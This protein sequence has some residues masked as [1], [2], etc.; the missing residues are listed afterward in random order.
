MDEPIELTAV[1]ELRADAPSPDAARLAALRWRLMA[2]VAAETDGV[3]ARPAR[4]R[5]PGHRAVRRT[6]VAAATAAAVTS[7]VLLS[8]PGPAGP[9]GPSGI[10]ARPTTA[11]T[12]LTMAAAH[13]ERLSPAV[14]GP[15]QWA[16]VTAYTCDERP[17]PTT[18]AEKTSWVRGDGRQFM[19]T[20][21]AGRKL[22]LER[23]GFPDV[24]YRALSRWPTEPHALL[25]KMGRDPRTQARQIMTVLAEAPAVP[26]RI[27]AALFRAL[28]L[29]PGADLVDRPVKDAMGRR[30]TAIDYRFSEQD[31]EYLILNPR[32]YAYL[33]FRTVSYGRTTAVAREVT[34]VVDHP[35]QLP[36][37]PVPPR[38]SHG[39]AI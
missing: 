22:V 18:C 8:L 19:V 3:P 17:A 16:Y 14:P 12:V 32:T 15:R 2:A 24:S 7:G 25:G 4:G 31:H 20:N 6:V 11:A 1:R 29:I 39:S 27:G 26:P 13:A 36:G 38:R 33:G 28:A 10:T 34:G 30:G 5:L 37:G 35:G 21:G 23:V 9:A